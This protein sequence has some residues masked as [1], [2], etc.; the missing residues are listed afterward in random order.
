MMKWIIT[1][2]LFINATFAFT[3]PKV[4]NTGKLIDV[5]SNYYLIQ[6]KSKKHI[7]VKPFLKNP[8]IGIEVSYPIANAPSK[9]DKGL[10]QQHA[11]KMVS[12]KE[13]TSDVIEVYLQALA[14]LSKNGLYKQESTSG[15]K[16]TTL[17][18]DLIAPKVCAEGTSCDNMCYFGGWA[19]TRKG[20][21]CQVPWNTKN[22]A[23]V[24]AVDS[25]VYDKDYSCGG[26][27]RFRCNPKIF[28]EYDSSLD[29]VQM[30]DTRGSKRNSKAGLCI[31]VSP[32]YKYATSQCLEASAKVPGFKEKL[33]ERY[34]SNKEVFENI[35]DNVNC[36]CDSQKTD[37]REFSCNAL[38][39]RLA[40]IFEK[41][42]HIEEEPTEEIEEVIHEEVKVQTEEIV[43]ESIQ[44]AIPIIPRDDSGEEESLVIVEQEEE[45]LPDDLIYYNCNFSDTKS[46]FEGK[47]SDCANKSVCL[48]KVTCESYSKEKK[49]YDIKA[50]LLAYCSC[51]VND[52]TE[53][54]NAIADR[55]IKTEEKK[56]SGSSSNQQ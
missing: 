50:N 48:K 41:P 11:L 42:V 23:K 8:K 36:F 5:T 14:D 56:S 47:N 19:S 37:K 20:G 43:E 52:A 53:C 2:L 27:D 39:S 26:K 15:P 4:Y 31:K 7:K 3:V 18:L 17:L 28:G 29:P 55:A 49:Q 51:D 12:Q 46:L 38:R 34:N 32:S 25:E 1:S 35:I 10:I 9:I 16:Y 30:V 33:R 45:P 24:K 21:Y 6:T 40:M 44:K 13:F 54:A 22:D